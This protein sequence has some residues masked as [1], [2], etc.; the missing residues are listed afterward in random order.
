MELF[1]KE[2]TQTRFITILSF[3]IKREQRVIHAIEKHREH[4]VPTQTIKMPHSH[5]DGY[6]RLL[7]RSCRARSKQ[8]PDTSQVRSHTEACPWPHNRMG[9]YL[10]WKEEGLFSELGSLL[11]ITGQQTASQG[12][13]QCVVAEQRPFSPEL[14]RLSVRER[15]RQGRRDLERKRESKQ[16]YVVG[17]GHW[18]LHRAW[19]PCQLRLWAQIKKENLYLASG[20]G[21][22]GLTGA[23]SRSLPTQAGTAHFKHKQNGRHQAGVQQLSQKFAICLSTAK[24]SWFP[25]SL[26]LGPKQQH[27]LTQRQPRE[28]NNGWWTSSLGKGPLSA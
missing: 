18:L 23:S 16:L 12:H 8:Y 2:K 24:F 19:A 7:K 11:L 28:V 22:V 26:I 17:T 27:G 1:C 4:T 10:N 6:S 3:L 20:H 15:E 9:C 5:N 14:V 13:E 21:S 25:L